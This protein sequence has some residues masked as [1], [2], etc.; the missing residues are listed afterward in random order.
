MSTRVDIV[1]EAYLV[2][3]AKMQD[4]VPPMPTAQA[5]AILEAGARCLLARTPL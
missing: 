4:A 1:P 5:R 2:E 3:F